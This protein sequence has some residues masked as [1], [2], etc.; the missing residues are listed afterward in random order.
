M[1]EGMA[2]KHDSGVTSGLLVCKSTC[3]NL[4]GCSQGPTRRR[5][6]QGGVSG[7]AEDLL[8]VSEVEAGVN[9][10][11]AVYGGRLQV[12]FPVGNQAQ[13][14]HLPCARVTW[15]RIGYWAIGGLD[16]GVWNRTVGDVGAEG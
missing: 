2:V 12:H 1:W 6:T 16:E 14:S 8:P 3:Y 4:V 10:R 5:S 13:V 9:F 15:A 7:P 11:P